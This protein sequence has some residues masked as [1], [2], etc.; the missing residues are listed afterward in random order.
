MRLARQ[1]CIVVEETVANPSAPLDVVTP[2]E[3]PGRRLR[4][5]RLLS[6]LVV[7]YALGIVGLWAWMHFQGDRSWAATIFLFG[8]RW[9]CALPLA[10]LVPA[11][12][13]WHRRLLWPLGITGMV[14][15]MPVMGL[16]LHFA[17][18]GQ[19]YTLRILT[20]NVAQSSFHPDELAE[21][22][23]TARPDVVALQEVPGIPPEI[24]WPGGWH[25]VHRDE[26]LVASRFPILELERLPMPYVPGKLAAIRYEIQCG[27]RAVQLFNLHLL[28]PRRGLEAVLDA[29]KGIDYSKIP[30]L[31]RSLRARD[32]ESR[33]ASDW[34]AQ[35][36]GAKIVVGDFNMPVDSV[37]YRQT[38]SWLTNAF[39]TSGLGFGFT[40]ITEKRGWSYGARIDHVLFS[41]PWRSVRAWIGPDIGSD[42]RPLLVDLD[43]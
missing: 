7:L 15:V 43:Q 31:E 12:A 37:I 14:I 22:I 19:P 39:S 16:Q 1:E 38:W 42:H 40:K 24:V 3:A 27:N 35:Y 5:K 17:G 20:C 26:L 41:P 4:P 30:R 8:P 11:A 32:A 23:E 13:V 6:V 34:I 21:L 33:L 25:V 18:A 10:L 2:K 29:N 28:S 9:V 36:P